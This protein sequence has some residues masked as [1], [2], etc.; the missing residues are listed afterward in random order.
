M[1]TASAVSSKLGATPANPT[2]SAA[3]ST[4]TGISHASERRSET[5]PKAGWMID[6]PTVTNSRRAPT[7]L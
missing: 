6:E 1:P 4:P 7:A 3:S 2:P 5:A